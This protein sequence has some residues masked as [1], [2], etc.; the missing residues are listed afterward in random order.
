MENDDGELII[1]WACAGAGNVVNDLQGGFLPV[2]SNEQFMFH[3][4]TSL[5]RTRGIVDSPGVGLRPFIQSAEKVAR[6]F[7]AM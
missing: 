3:L 2:H 1:G 6:L 4:K 7:I 5:S